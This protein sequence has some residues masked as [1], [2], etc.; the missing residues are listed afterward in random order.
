[1]ANGFE[2]Y[3]IEE[4]L[5]KNIEAYMVQV[6]KEL[7]SVAQEVCS[8]LEK[9][10]IRM[11]DSMIDQFYS[12]PTSSYIRHGT[13]AVGTKNGQTLYRAQNIHSTNL[14]WKQQLHVHLD[15]S[16]MLHDGERPYRYDDPEDVFGFVALGYRFVNFNYELQWDA[17]YHG[18]YFSYSGDLYAA[19]IE[20]FDKDF[21]SIAENI[22]VE[23]LKRRR[24]NFL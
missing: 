18:K 7:N 24:G 22:F 12:Y 13:S 11:Y 21:E 9:E 10:L 14:A 1:M 20:G 16:D 6:N 17:S 4:M 5:N 15:G 2:L 8:E 19:F 3:D 23:R